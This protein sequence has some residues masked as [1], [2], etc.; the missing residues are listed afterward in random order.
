MKNDKFIDIKKN[1]FDGTLGRVNLF[2]DEKAVMYRDDETV[3]LQDPIK[4]GNQDSVAPPATG[5]EGEDVAAAVAEE[6]GAKGSRGDNF[7]EIIMH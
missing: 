6:G 1:R 3:L 5:G 2:F 4:L 7:E